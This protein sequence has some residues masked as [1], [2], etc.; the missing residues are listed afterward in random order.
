MI[1]SKA[2]DSLAVL[3][4]AELYDMFEA[5]TDPITKQ[6]LKDECDWRAK[7]YASGQEAN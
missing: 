2:Y 3:S 4:D 6:L 1:P 5:E 7:A